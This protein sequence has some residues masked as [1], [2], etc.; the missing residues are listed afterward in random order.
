MRL[1]GLP[2]VTDYKNL[3]AVAEKASRDTRLVTTV[4]FP[5]KSTADVI[6]KSCEQLKINIV[7]RDVYGQSRSLLENMN[8][9][10][11]E[12]VKLELENHQRVNTLS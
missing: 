1:R 5:G 7:G 2:D 6:K 11:R 3:A 10:D 4:S 8:N 12:I 9:F